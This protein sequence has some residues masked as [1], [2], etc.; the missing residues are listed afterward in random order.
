MPDIIYMIGGKG[1]QSGSSGAPSL[2]AGGAFLSSGSMTWANAQ[3]ANGAVLADTGINGGDITQTPAGSTIRITDVTFANAT[4]NAWVDIFINLVSASHQNGRYKITA[5]DTNIIDITL[6]HST[7]EVCRA[8]VGGALNPVDRVDLQIAVDLAAV[9]DFVN[10]SVDDTGSVSIPFGDT[11]DIDQNSGSVN[12]RITIQGVD[13]A[14][15]RLTSGAELPVLLGDVVLTNGLINIGTNKLY[16]DIRL[17]DLNGGGAGKARHC[18]LNLSSFSDFNRVFDCK[19]HNTDRTPLEWVG[20]RSAFV[21]LE[22]YDADK[23]DGG[24]NAM[25]VNGDRTLVLGCSIHDNPGA[26]LVINDFGCHVHNNIIYDNGGIGILVGTL[27][28]QSAISNNTVYGNDVGIFIN[29]DADFCFIWN[30]TSSGNTTVNWDLDADA[31][32]L[33]YF[34]YNH[35]HDGGGDVADGFTWADIGEGNN[36]TGDPL[37][38]SV[39]DGSEDFTPRHGSALLG[40]GAPIAFATAAGPLA[41]T[42]YQDIGAISRQEPKRYPRPAWHGA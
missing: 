33:G 38:V 30:N 24:F 18:L 41:I 14:G 10:I 35:S 12:S 29:T 42:N 23:A 11:L 13:N 8:T 2:Q 22:V 15:V 7:D 20:D 16:W 25:T 6:T 40:A 26:G 17:I 39:T 9:G 5:S 4:N 37:F 21:G 1:D 28:D 36:I 34:A 31:T 3:A 32:H 19:L 27:G